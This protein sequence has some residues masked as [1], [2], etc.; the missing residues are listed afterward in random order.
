MQLPPSDLSLDY[1]TLSAPEIISRELNIFEQ[2][3][4]LW[5]NRFQHLVNYIWHNI[6]QPL[7]VAQLAEQI[8]VSMFHF[9][10]IFH[11]AFSQPVADYIRKLR[12]L[13]AIKDLTDTDMSITEIALSS[14][15]SS[16][17]SFAKALKQKTGFNS[18]QIRKMIEQQ[19][20]TQ[21]YSLYHE[22]ASE[23][24]QN[25]LASIIE[26]KHFSIVSHKQRF[27]NCIKVERA[28]YQ[29]MEKA[30]CA[31]V[32]DNKQTMYSLCYDD[33]YT[34]PY[35][36]ISYWVG[37]S[38]E[39]ENTSHTLPAGNYLTVTVRLSSMLEYLAAWHAFEC[40]ALKHGLEFSS[41]PSIEISQPSQVT[42][43]ASDLRIEININD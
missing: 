16:S 3:S 41:Q 10:R 26:E 12:L 11:A 4:P 34:V 29:R 38:C 7:P 2:M 17:Q 43:L 14:G 37:E 19:G 33:P 20:L 23:H 30:W 32:S 24:E 27:L 6:E 15:F 35:K 39:P 36:Q 28:T 5:R 21:L 9:H 40:Y 31:H 22:L 42:D 13:K 18:S 8:H 1:N 25:G